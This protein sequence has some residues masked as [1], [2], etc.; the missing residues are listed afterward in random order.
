[1]TQNNLKLIYTFLLLF[2]LSFS[3][4]SFGQQTNPLVSTEEAV[5]ESVKLV[6]CK[7]EDR[8][9][10]VKKL[11][12]QMGAKPDEITVE[13]FNKDKVSNVVV[14]KKGKTDETIIIGAHY[15]KVD[16]G[17]GVVDNW[18]GIAIIA[19]LYKTFSQM[20]TQ[21]SYIF[22]AFDQEEKGLLGSEGMAKA[23]PKENRAQYCLMVNFD[24][25]GTGAPMALG[26]ASSSKM[27]A[28]AKKLG[29]ENKFKFIDITVEG[30]NA[31]SSSFK[32]RDI[33]AITMSG[34]DNSWMNYMHS[35]NDQLE[36]INMKSVYYSYRFGLVYLAKLDSTGCQEYK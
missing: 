31:D 20:E 3:T 18:T 15:D 27:L 19:H 14:K 22:V 17:C 1:M 16:A 2:V 6:P 25:F 12:G 21:K 36:K 28:L 8:T 35:K 30:A 11:F 23:I 10:A 4:Q 5:T 34:L 33:P 24:S 9:E 7:N 32:S 26:N 29:E 13:K